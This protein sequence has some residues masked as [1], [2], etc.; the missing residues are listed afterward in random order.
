MNTFAK[1]NL[2]STAYGTLGANGVP[3]PSLVVVVRK[4]DP[5]QKR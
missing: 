2:R 3:A 5:E 4:Q 1:V